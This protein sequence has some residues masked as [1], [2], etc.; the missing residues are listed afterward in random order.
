VRRERGRERRVELGFARRERARVAG[1]MDRVAERG[2]VDA[3]TRGSGHLVRAPR[4][5]SPVLGLLGG[6]W[7]TPYIPG[8]ALFCSTCLDPFTQ[9]MS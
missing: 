5:F 4:R 7:T 9:N 2:W 1:G 8:F 3:G 6:K